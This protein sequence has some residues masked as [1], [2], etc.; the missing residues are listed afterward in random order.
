MRLV[1]KT[2][3]QPL[4]SSSPPLSLLCS[5]SSLYAR[6]VLGERERG[7][8]RHGMGQ[9]VS[10][11]GSSYEHGFFSAVQDGHLE[12]VRSAIDED[13]SLLR[14]ATIYD[15]LSALH[16]AAANGRVEVR[17]PCPK[18]SPFSA[19]PFLYL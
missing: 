15:R 12:T 9:G 18:T 11:A 13:P 19:L 14:R 1:N 2:S 10:C 16:I 17:I 6:P 7:D 3:Q 8:E 5:R 4:S